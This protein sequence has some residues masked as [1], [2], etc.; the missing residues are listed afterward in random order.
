VARVL[1]AHAG[2]FTPYTFFYIAVLFAAWFGG[3]GPALL[4]IAIGAVASVSSA[5]LPGLLPFLPHAPLSGFEFYFIVTLTAT[6]LL[7]AQRRSALQSVRSAALAR[8]AQ[9][10]LR[11]TFDYAPVGICRLGAGGVFLDVNSQFCQ[12]VGYS[13]HQLQGRA[14]SDILHC[15]DAPQSAEHFRLLWNTGR[16]TYRREERYVR[17]NDSIIWADVTVSAVRDAAGRPLYAICVAQDI[18]ARKT[19]EEQLGQAQKIESIGA[20]AGGIAHDFNNLLTG[21]LGNATLA[22]ETVPRGGATGR[23]LQEVITAASRA[24]QLTAQLLAY[25]GKGTFIVRDLDISAVVRRSLELIRPLLDPKIELRLALDDHL[26]AFRADPALLQQLVTNLAINAMEAIGD[27]TPGAISISTARARF[28]AFHPPPPASIGQLRDGEYVEIRVQDTGSGIE[29]AQV[30]KIF[31][32]FF[33][34]KF[35]GRGLGLAAVSGIVRSHTGAI[36]VLTAPGQG[37][38]F[39]VFLP[40]T[41]HEN[42][43]P[44]KRPTTP[45]EPVSRLTK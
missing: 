25:A 5:V 27:E 19:A 45:A 40:V 36:V 7:E 37:S 10:Q 23:M 2:Y 3:L 13:A 41:A 35:M 31:D 21:I 30:S 15:E 9:T 34:T 4:A 42:Q 26:P 44:L 12:I 28:N 14:Y 43:L 6:I 24:A 18:T 16:A 29:A 32:P 39:S 22:L 17:G 20:L 11:I 8:E 38:V 33:T 1:L